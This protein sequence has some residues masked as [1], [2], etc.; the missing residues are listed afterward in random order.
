MTKHLLPVVALLVALGFGPAPTAQAQ[1]KVQTKSDGEKLKSKEDGIVTKTKVADDGKV[2]IKAKAEDGSKLKG[3]TQPVKTK[4][5][6]EEEES[7]AP[8]KSIGVL[9]GGTLMTPDRDIVGNALNSTDHTTLIATANAAGLVAPLRQSGP[10]TVFAPTNEAFNKL[11][12][13]TVNALVMPNQRGRL[14]NLLSY[15]VVAGR[16]TAADLQD[17]QHLTTVEGEVLTVVR[18]GSAVLLKDMKG[19]LAAITI[20]DVISSNGIAHI[21]DK[22]L[23]PS[24]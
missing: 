10:F 22:V 3:K 12:A 8:Q 2:K 16:L 18:N 6:V 15:H 17:G 14:A 7:G 5:Q 1:T 11:P 13:G 21:I 19:G 24:R 20:P 4:P 23:I 9:V